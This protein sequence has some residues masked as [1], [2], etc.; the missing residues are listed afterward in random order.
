[1]RLLEGFGSRAIKTGRRS[2]TGSRSPFQ[3]A[4]SVL[5]HT[6]P[7]CRLHARRKP[8]ANVWTRRGGS[9][10]ARRPTGRSRDP[11]TGPP[12]ELV[13]SAAVPRSVRR[14]WRVTRRLCAGAVHVDH[15]GDDRCAAGEPAF[16]GHGERGM[17]LPVRVMPRCEPGMN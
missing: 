15:G 1:M 3:A 8:G 4:H 6:T 16:A 14:V 7:T 13:P 2:L 12:G 5:D 11:R 17:T 9:G 10:R